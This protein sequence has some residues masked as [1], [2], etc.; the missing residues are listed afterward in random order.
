MKNY[1]MKEVS[2]PRCGTSFPVK[3]WDLISIRDN[4]EMKQKVRD[5]SA[6]R[7]TCPH[8]GASIVL[9]YPFVYL[10]IDA[11]EIIEVQGSGEH[12]ENDGLWIRDHAST[13]R[14]Y[15]KR[16]VYS[17]NDFMEKLFIWDEGLND[18]LIELLKESAR[19]QLAQKYADRKIDEIFFSVSSDH[20]P[21]LIFRSGG[22]TKSGM[23]IDEKVYQA[24]ESAAL[25]TIEAA[26]ENDLVIDGAWARN[27]MKRLK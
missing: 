25:P 24:L 18:K 2:C 11:G 17:L 7:A 16:V 22:K 19:E 6:F 9:T 27:M 14:N 13:L 1:E 21:G 23:E 15:K 5:T 26:S 12:H 20:K 3:Y 8:C 4:P 10:D